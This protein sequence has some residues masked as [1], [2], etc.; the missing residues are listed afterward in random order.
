MKSDRNP[1]DILI[2]QF[3]YIY[4][5]YNKESVKNKGVIQL[6]LKHVNLTI[7]CYFLADGN[8][9]KLEFGRHPDPSCTLSST[10][11]DWL[12]LGAGKLNPVWGVI[13]GRLKF[14]GITK[15]FDELMPKSAMFKL[16]ND[17]PNDPLIKFETEKPAA[18]APESIIVI[19]G[20]PR[21]RNGFTFYYLDK[22]L[23][24]ISKTKTRLEVIDICKH[25]IK[26]CTGCYSCWKNAEKGCPIKDDV[27]ELYSKVDQADMLI[28]AFPLYYDGVPGILKNFIDRGLYRMH[29]YMIE[30]NGTTRH[31]RRVQRNQRMT[32]FSVCGFPEY[33]HFEAVQKFFRQ[34][35]HGSHIPI[36][37]QIYRTACEFLYSN[38][39]LYKK[40]N[41]VCNNLISAGEEL[42]RTGLISNKLIKQ[43]ETKINRNDF[44]IEA[45]K[46]WDN[47]ILKKPIEYSQV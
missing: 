21:G 17:L 29:P 36:A 24:G 2:N 26:P 40:I 25:K 4:D 18:S 31:P 42:G 44:Q 15:I 27:N 38:P 7:E 8:N 37:N 35:S 30:G 34:I 32:I 16:N 28:Y 33:E 14:K 47:V 10:L 6:F 20:A 1:Q 19:N 9:I 12:D 3:A 39:M 46:F 43:I 23:E 5:V 11:Y 22:F 13:T 41:I 45:S